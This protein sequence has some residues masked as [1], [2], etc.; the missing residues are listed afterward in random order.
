MNLKE[1]TFTAGMVTFFFKTAYTLF[2]EYAGSRFGVTFYGLAG[3][4]CTV[5]ELFFS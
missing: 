5:G 1:N 4:G 2:L 3:L